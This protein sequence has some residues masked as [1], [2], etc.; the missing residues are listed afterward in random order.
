[1]MAV[2]NSNGHK[3]KPPHGPRRSPN[4]SQYRNTPAAMGVPMA[5]GSNT[6]Q[7]NNNTP[8]RKGGGV[9]DWVEISALGVYM[10]YRFE[11]D[12]LELCDKT[13]GE[14]ITYDIPDDDLDQPRDVCLVA[15]I[16]QANVYRI[17]DRLSETHHL[18]FL[19]DPSL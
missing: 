2:V 14:V 5:T 4:V 11:G 15:E 9:W 1:M 7:Q 16:I 13:T 17:A 3:R 6:R 19:V 10:K 12:T 18:E 8:A